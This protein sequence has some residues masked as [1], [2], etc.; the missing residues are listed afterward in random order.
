[1]SVL[2]SLDDASQTT[3]STGTMHGE[4]KEEEIN[5]LALT[6][7]SSYHFIE[8]CAYHHNQF[9]LSSYL[10]MHNEII[11]LTVSK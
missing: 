3:T 10:Q 8:T 2:P 5:R 11:L 6:G 9:E 4:E 7:S 1:M